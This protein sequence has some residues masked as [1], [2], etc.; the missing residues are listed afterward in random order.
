MSMLSSTK[1]RDRQQNL[2]VSFPTQTNFH[3]DGRNNFIIIFFLELSRKK[4]TK[5]KGDDSWFL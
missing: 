4:G 3:G 1:K 5:K 2:P